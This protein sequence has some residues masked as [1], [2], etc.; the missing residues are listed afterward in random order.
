[1]RLSS[2]KTRVYKLCFTQGFKMGN[3]SQMVVLITALHLWPLSALAWG[4]QGHRMIGALAEDRLTPAAQ[5]EVRKLLGNE[6]LAAASTWADEMR[7]SSDNRAF[8][9]SYASNW[10]YV[11][12]PAGSTYATSPRN[13]R[14][15]ALLALATFSAI[16]TDEPIP[17]G[18]VQDGLRLYFPRF[19]PHAA[20]VKRF[21]LRFL[22]HILGDLQQPLHT[23]HV[24]DRG[25]N[26]IEFRWQ[27][28]NT[29][30]HALW[31]SAL[32]GYTNIDEAAYVRRL[33][34][35]LDHIPASDL[36]NYEAAD[37][38]TW[39]QEASRMLERIYS[40]L[41]NESTDA[42]AYAAEF[43]PTVELQL[44]KGGVRTAWFLNN[45]FGGWPV[46]AP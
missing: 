41:P 1:M 25:G 40:R 37:V 17:A 6:D 18:V 33:R 8:W 27:G 11:N 16:L 15:D 29:N 23:G 2:K 7:G 4:T 9:S 35:R 20:E 43:V 39:L 46:G 24:D 12:I 28:R 5:A 31:D 45:I 10:H 22:L 26:A 38:S 32:L 21:A 19:D 36:R 3:R 13:P 34:A 44:L 42:K 30:L 14:G